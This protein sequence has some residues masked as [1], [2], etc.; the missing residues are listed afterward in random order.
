MDEA[1]RAAAELKELIESGLNKKAIRYYHHLLGMIEL[2]RKNFSKAVEFFK[3]GISLLQYQCFFEY[4]Q[5]LIPDSHAL[6]MEPLALAYY[7]MGDL[8]SA[9]EEYEKIT[10][11]SSGRLFFGDIYVKSFYMLGK[12]YEQQNDTAKAMEHYERFLDL[13]KDA[14][15]GIVEVE[16]AKERV[17]ALT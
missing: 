17:A 16:D 14:D 15:T 9:Q 3:R 12:I 1:Q 13:W 10:S 6:F 5:W 11:L 8:D 4:T 2:K 7:K